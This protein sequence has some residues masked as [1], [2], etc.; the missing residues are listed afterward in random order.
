MWGYSSA[1]EH[2]TAD[3]KVPSSNLGAPSQS[4]PSPSAG[5]ALISSRSL[6]F[7]QRRREKINTKTLLLWLCSVSLDTFI[8]LQDDEGASVSSEDI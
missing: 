7:S 1:A 5:M 8:P 4:R 2:L 3:Q 6:F